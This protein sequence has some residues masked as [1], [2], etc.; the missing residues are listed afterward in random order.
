MPFVDQ[1]NVPKW[2]AADEPAS[3]PYDP[4]PAKPVGH[5]VMVRRIPPSQSLPVPLRG[6]M[7][8]LNVEQSIPRELSQDYVG[9]RTCQEH[10][11]VIFDLVIAGVSYLPVTAVAKLRAAGACPEKTQ[12]RANERALPFVVPRNMC[13]NNLYIRFLF[14]GKDRNTTVPV[15]CSVDP[16]LCTWDPFA[17]SD[18]DPLEGLIY[19][20]SNIRTGSTEA[21]FTKIILGANFFQSMF[22]ALH[23]MDQGEDPNATPFVRFAPQYRHEMRAFAFPPIQS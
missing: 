7:M 22:V 2:H 17:Q 16:F 10:F 8:M 4:A 9:K 12:D 5:S 21:V 15:F 6:Y 3:A 13:T 11:E 19:P 20:L 18:Q 14:G 23:Y 1:D